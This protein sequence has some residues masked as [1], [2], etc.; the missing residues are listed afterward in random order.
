[1][2]SCL[3]WL[4]SWVLP[5]RWLSLLPGR[6]L[7]AAVIANFTAAGINPRRGF[8]ADMGPLRELPGEVG[9]HK[10]P[11][12]VLAY[13]IGPQFW[14]AASYPLATLL[15]RGHTW[16]PLLLVATCCGGWWAALLV[17]G[18]DMVADGGEGREGAFLWAQLSQLPSASQVLLSPWLH[19]GIVK[20]RPQCLPT[21]LQL[22]RWEVQG[23][24]VQWSATCLLCLRGECRALFASKSKCTAVV[25]KWRPAVH[26]LPTQ[27]V[28]HPH[29][30][31]PLLLLLSCREHLRRPS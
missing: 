24:I 15:W 10:V 23:L 2:A 8:L 4:W 26:I 29:P 11:G 20:V 30:P 3:A 28:P 27:A 21:C 5:E 16:L 6:L 9:E 31:P 1:M 18:K 7:R 22:P 17:Q 25:L 14:W 19:G 13:E 12:A